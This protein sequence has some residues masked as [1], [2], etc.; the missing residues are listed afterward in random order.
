[1]PA[2]TCPQ[3]PLTKP[4]PPPQYWHVPVHA[5]SQQT[6]P[7]EE[8]LAQ[9]PLAQ[10]CAPFQHCIPLVRWMQVLLELQ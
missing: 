6:D 7:S 2:C 3:V 10:L 5:V 8:E 9:N 1:L 4:G